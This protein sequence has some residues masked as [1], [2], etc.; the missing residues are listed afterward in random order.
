MTINDDLK[1]GFE[2]PRPQLR[3]SNWTSLNGYWQFAEDS[4]DIGLKEGW[5]NSATVF[6]REVLIPFPPGSELSEITDFSDCDVVWYRRI[7]KGQ[8]FPPK[9]DS[10]EWHLNFEAID[11]V[12]DVWVNGHHLC[13]HT[14]CGTSFSV[15]LPEE[16]EYEIVVRV[17]D[18]KIDQSQPR[19]KQDWLDD[20]HDIWYRRSTGIWRDV[21]L[22][23]APSHAIERIW[24]KFDLDNATVSA[25]IAFSQWVSEGQLRVGLSLRGEK[26]AAVQ[27]DI[28]G[29]SATVV[30]EIPQVRSRTEWD[31][32]LWFP[33]SPNLIDAQLELKVGSQSDE[34]LSY[35]GLRAVDTKDGYLR[36]N[37]KPVY[38]RGIL[39]QGYW[40]QS[41]Y[42]APSSDA[43]M[44]DLE[45]VRE[46]GFNTIRI[47]QRTPDRRYLAMADFLGI[48]V[49]AEFPAAFEYSRRAINWTLSQWSSILDRDAS[50]PSIVV[51]V[52]F[53]E[54]WG[55]DTI[56]TNSSQR[57]FVNSI[58]E[59]TKA[60]D[61]TRLVVANDGWEQLDTDIVSTHDYATTANELEIAY[62]DAGNIHQ[63]IHGIGPQGRPILLNSSADLGDRPMMVTEFGGISL[64]V[65]EESSWGYAVVSNAKEFQERVS[66]LFEALYKSPVLT[67][68]CYTQLTDT[69]QEANGL[70][71]EDR[72]PKIP[73]SQI[74]RFVMG[75]S[76]DNQI[77]P[78]RFNQP[79]GSEE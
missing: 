2:Y 32:L 19:G 29:L 31:R 26:I 68:W 63:T 48:M 46:M 20:P 51:W 76:F 12:A 64:P 27:A 42:T 34:V 7:L 24:W 62:R 25:E 9:P 71:T 78:R 18:H 30:L 4:E 5:F 35:L 21:W 58:V 11:F 53:N 39:D 54:S 65:G 28:Q 56:S 79:A 3:R 41:Y 22:E 70:L 6:D 36:I 8:D 38:V 73:I 75:N 49:W 60:K 72:V 17:E 57:H 16:E 10:E 15:K 67:G 66:S 44:R 43:Q 45:L 23:S 47:H 14:G 40:R 50:N 13:R 1:M 77:R 61:S 37:R 55:V 59:L 52:P 69:L 33:S 74:N